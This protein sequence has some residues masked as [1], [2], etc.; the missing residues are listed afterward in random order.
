MTDTIPTSPRQALAYYQRA[1]EL[2]IPHRQKRE[3]EQ[4]TNPDTDAR[5]LNE[6]AHLLRDSECELGLAE[7][8]TSLVR[9]TGRD[10]APYPGNLP[11]HIPI[12]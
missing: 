5:V 12:E 2:L 8:I 4:I 3:R 7:D 11:T 6:I 9:S 1:A 10:L